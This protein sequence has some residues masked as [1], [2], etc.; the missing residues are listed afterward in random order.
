MGK[1]TIERY[2][3]DS[4]R[5][6]RY[7]QLISDFISAYSAANSGKAVPKYLQ[8]R[9]I[10]RLAYLLETHEHQ[11]GVP[12]E[13]FSYSQFSSFYQ[14]AILSNSSSSL[15]SHSY[16]KLLSC[17]L[18]Y[19]VVNKVL[20]PAQ[21]ANHPY[22]QL[23]KDLPSRRQNYQGPSI[24]T[25]VGTSSSKN[26]LQ[27][28]FDVYSQ[29]MLFSEEE[30]ESLLNAIFRNEDQDCMPRAI[31]TLAWCGVEVKQIPLIKKADVD[32][33]HM[34]I[35]ATKQNQLPQDIVIPSSFCRVNLEKAMTAESIY[36]P[37]RVGMREMPFFGRDDYVIRG[38]KGA[39]RAETSDSDASGYY[40][41][42]NANRVYTVRQEQLGANNPF[43]NKKVLVSSCYKSGQFLRLYKTKQPMERLWDVYGNTFVYSYKKWLS[44]KQLNLK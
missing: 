7:Q 5:I 26:T 37:C 15:I 34:V 27:Q 39:N 23:F 36:V 21:A 11:C 17:Y 14:S 6:A 24:D 32:L 12:F 35:Y 13:S 29:Q 41:V 2:N 33:A 4:A 10:P 19:L 44:Y 3:N 20:T 40:I 22:H 28:A 42:N 30:F 18:D 8:T 1:T 16:L 9:D 25:A 38:T 31:Y 43:K